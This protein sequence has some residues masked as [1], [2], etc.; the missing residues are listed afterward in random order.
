MIFIYS[1]SFSEGCEKTKGQ[2][3]RNQDNP[4]P[5]QI[6]LDRRGSGL[7]GSIEGDKG[8]AFLLCDELLQRHF[9]ADSTHNETHCRV[10]YGKFENLCQFK[11]QGDAAGE[12]AFHATPILNRDKWIRLDLKHT[13]IPGI[14]EIRWQ[15]G[16]VARSFVR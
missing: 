16:A 1:L 14:R 5:P 13:C 7:G 9:E 12:D 4:Y 2:T 15:S 6:C 10:G 8:E 11:V 3:C